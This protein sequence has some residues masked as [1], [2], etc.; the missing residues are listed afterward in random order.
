[1]GT[2]DYI[3]WAQFWCPVPVAPTKAPI[4]TAALAYDEVDARLGDDAESSEFLTRVLWL[5]S[6]IR[7]AALG[8]RINELEEAR[9]PV[10]RSVSVTALIREGL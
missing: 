9:W 6:A 7:L 4:R 8:W 3:A 5:E 10:R 1:M 2:D